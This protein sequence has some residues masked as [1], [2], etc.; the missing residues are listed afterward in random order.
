MEGHTMKRLL[1]LVSLLVAAV[2]AQ[3]DNGAIEAAVRGASGA[4][5]VRAP[6]TITETQTNNRFDGLADAQGNYVSPPS[7]V[8][9]YSVGVAMPGFK[10]YTRTNQVVVA[11]E[12]VAALGG[13]LKQNSEEKAELGGVAQ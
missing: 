4:A 6:V 13:S 8:G 12:A 2:P 10:A 11:S 5:M 7:K 1:L 9:I 3:A